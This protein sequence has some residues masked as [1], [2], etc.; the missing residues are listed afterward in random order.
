MWQ[1]PS[2]SLLLFLLSTRVLLVRFRIT[3][4]IVFQGKYVCLFITNIYLN[5]IYRMISIQSTINEKYGKQVQIV[6]KKGGDTVLWT[7]H[8]VKMIHRVVWKSM[9]KAMHA[10]RCDCALSLRCDTIISPRLVYSVVRK[11]VSYIPDDGGVDGG[12]LKFLYS[13][14]NLG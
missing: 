2:S 12:S 3:L 8:S 6:V 10:A 14:S 13:R 1:I 4:K 7:V 5:G 9:T 11:H